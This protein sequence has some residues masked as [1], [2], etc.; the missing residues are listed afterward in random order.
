M[1]VCRLH[2]HSFTHIE[3]G[4]ETVLNVVYLSFRR[5]L[6]LTVNTPHGLVLRVEEVVFREMW[7]PR[8]F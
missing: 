2:R 4:D 7:F 3:K 6:A 8:V 5:S 1:I